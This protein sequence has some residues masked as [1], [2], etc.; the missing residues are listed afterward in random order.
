MTEKEIYTNSLAARMRIA[1]NGNWSVDD[2]ADL[3]ELAGIWDK[4]VNAEAQ[5]NHKV[6][7]EAAKI[8][9]VKVE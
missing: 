1:G 9:K 7:I 6:T 3:C 4:W 8:L 2:M 5:D